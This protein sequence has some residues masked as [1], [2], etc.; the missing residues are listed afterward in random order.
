MM[1][2]E[3][4]L[5]ALKTSA[6]ND[7]G[8]SIKSFETWDE[9]DNWEPAHTAGKSYM[10]ENGKK[11]GVF[12]TKSGLQYEVLIE[13]ATEGVRPKASDIV[14]VHYEGTLIDGTVF[15]SSII[16]GEQAVF[17]LDRVISGWT[18]GLQLMSVGEKYRFV[19]PPELAYGDR[20]LGGGA[21]PANSTLIFEVELIDVKGNLDGQR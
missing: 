13:R 17:S 11:P 15:D 4:Q 20:E 14:E 2:S 7:D 16:R 8:M 19:I 12:T 3:E 6:D 5:T 21:V 18:E 9:A 10:A 1:I